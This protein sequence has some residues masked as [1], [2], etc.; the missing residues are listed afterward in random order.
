MINKELIKKLQMYNLDANVKVCIDNKLHDFSV[1]CEAND[2]Q[3][4]LKCS[5]VLFDVDNFN[6][7]ETS[8][9]K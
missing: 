6:A 2:S 7:K 5:V 1:I 8:G 9:S 3:S 4:N